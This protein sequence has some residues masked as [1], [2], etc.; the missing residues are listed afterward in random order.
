MN[1]QLHVCCC[2]AHANCRRCCAPGEFIAA[3]GDAN[4]YAYTCELCEAKSF[5]CTGTV[6]ATATTVALAPGVW[7]ET[8]GQ[9][10]VRQCWNEDACA[11]G[12]P[13]AVVAAAAT[14]AGAADLAVAAATDAY[15]ASAYEVCISCLAVMS[16]HSSIDQMT[17]T[18]NDCRHRRRQHHG[19]RC[20]D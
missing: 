9:Q 15:C 7:R 19:H 8:L 4:A 3:T 10:L 11:G 16:H 1:C 6:G 18:E 20:R 17:K 12:A 13:D 5:N 14:A 2:F